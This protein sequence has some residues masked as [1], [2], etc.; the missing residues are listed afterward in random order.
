MNKKVTSNKT[1]YLLVENELKKLQTFDSSIF[2]YKTILAFSG[3]PDT[4]S[5]WV[6]KELSNEKITPPFALYKSLSAKLVWMN[7]SRIRLE[8]EGSCLKQDKAH[9]TPN[10][11]VHLYIVYELNIWSQELNA[12]FTLKHCL[13]RAVK[14]T[15]NANPNKYSYSEYGI[16]FDSRSL[17]MIPNF[18]WGK[19]TII[20]ELI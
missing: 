8:F 2:I 12:E 1:K 6:S 13:F 11:V 10:N 4:I 16:G 9:F 14:L 19:T 17:F 7:N 5:G 18:D 3:L 15:N 20:L